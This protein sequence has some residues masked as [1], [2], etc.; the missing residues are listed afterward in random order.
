MSVTQ[1]VLLV[2]GMGTRLG[3]LTAQ[4][5]KPMLSVAG[6]PFLEHLLVK[7]ARHGFTEVLL[8]AG[9]R[10][11]VLVDWLT[12]SQVGARLGLRIEVVVEAEPMGTGGALVQARDRLAPT[13]L[14]ANGDTWFDFDWRAL[15]DHTDAPAVMAL[16]E[17]AVA[18]RYETAVLEAGRVVRFR[19]RTGE[20]SPG[21]INGGVY[22]IS[23]AALPD[24][25]GAWSLEADFLPRVALAGELGGQVFAGDFID[26]GV[27]ESLAAAQALLAR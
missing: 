23:R 26:I 18:D 19:P 16:R 6:K 7:A 24:L 1:C 13:F 5:P 12:Q 10:A 4:T 22:R 9:F 14:L 17:I 2:G 27:P 11:D 20:A 3:D 8:L 25:P 21:L 15:A